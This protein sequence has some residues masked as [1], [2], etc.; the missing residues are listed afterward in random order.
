M[1]R[2]L[3]ALKVCAGKTRPRQACA[4]RA[5]SPPKPAA[6]PTNGGEFLAR[7]RDELGLD[8]E[9]LTREMEARLAVS[10]CAR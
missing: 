6:S 10:G 5:W 8:I 1:T 7:V 9:I 3:E 2:T 4:A